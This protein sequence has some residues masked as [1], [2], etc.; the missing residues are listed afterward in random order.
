MVGIFQ[1]STMKKSGTNNERVPWSTHEVIKVVQRTVSYVPG[2]RSLRDVNA[3]TK[4]TSRAKIYS[5]PPNKGRKM[6]S[7]IEAHVCQPYTQKW[8]QKGENSYSD[9]CRNSGRHPL[10]D[11]RQYRSQAIADRLPGRFPCSEI[12]SLTRAASRGE[13]QIFWTLEQVDWHW[14]V[15]SAGTCISQNSWPHTQASRFR[16]G[17]LEG[18]QWHV[19]CTAIRT[20]MFGAR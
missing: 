10:P 3:K 14:E 9:T 2:G 20:T 11:Q 19:L 17:W 1:K 18:V 5:I 13:A 7:N 16:D 4:V 8:Y 12:G 6:Y 15:C